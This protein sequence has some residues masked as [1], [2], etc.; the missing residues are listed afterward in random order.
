MKENRN[1]FEIRGPGPN[2]DELKKSSE[3]S[4]LS[5]V[6]SHAAFSHVNLRHYA[7]LLFQSRNFV[8]RYVAYGL[9]HV[10]D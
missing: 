8:L 7:N 9:I 6:L 1:D 10:T 2:F 4:C 5:A 3:V